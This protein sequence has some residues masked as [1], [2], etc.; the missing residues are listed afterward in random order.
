[1]NKRFK[2]ISNGNRNQNR[3][4]R[5]CLVKLLNPLLHLIILVKYTGKKM[6]AK[7]NGSCLKQVIITFNHGK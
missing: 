3:N 5:D 6:Y 7:F 1:M 4:L 2:K